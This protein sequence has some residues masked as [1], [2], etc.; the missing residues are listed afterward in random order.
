MDHFYFCFHSIGIHAPADAALLL[1]TLFV[2]MISECERSWVY[3]KTKSAC[4]G[5]FV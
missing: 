5:G 1:L 2:E 3:L 4:A